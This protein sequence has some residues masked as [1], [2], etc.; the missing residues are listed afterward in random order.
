VTHHRDAT[1]KLAEERRQGWIRDHIHAAERENYLNDRIEEGFIKIHCL[2]N[3]RDP[4]PHPA[5]VYWQG[6]KIAV[7]HWSTSKTIFNNI[8]YPFP[9]WIALQAKSS[10]PFFGL[11]QQQDPKEN[12]F[13]K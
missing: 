7:E 6:P 2:N 10:I 11:L 4:I 13:C 9:V 1:L 12:P 8:T 5:P 3:E